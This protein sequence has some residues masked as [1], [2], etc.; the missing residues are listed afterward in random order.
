MTVLRYDDYAHQRDFTADVAVVGT[1]AGGAVAAAELAEAGLDVVM[2]EEGDHHPT[3]SFNP[4]LAETQ[5]RLY[6]DVAG[7]LLFGNPPIPYLE[8]RCVGGSTVIN[9]GMAWRAPEEVLAEWAQRT[10]SEDLGPER[11]APRFDR[12]EASVHARPQI[13]ESIGADN[14]MMREGARR[15]DWRWDENLRAQDHCVGTNQCTMGCPTG[16]K[17]STLVNYVPRA[18]AAGARCL[19]GVRVRKLRIERGRCTGVEGVAPEPRNRRDGHRVTVR[20]RTVVVAC[21]AVQ[22]PHLLKRHRLGRPSRRLGRH[23]L[24]HPNVKTMAVFPDA[25]DA[26]KGVNQW[27]QVR[28]FH[29]EGIVLALNMVA[30]GQ[31]GAS[32]PWIDDEAW[33]LLT[34]YRRMV[35][36]GGLIEDSTSGVVRRGPGDFALPTYRV[37]RYDHER[38]MRAARLLGELWFEMGAESVLPPVDGMPPL[39]SPDDLRRLDADRVRPKDVDL[40]TVHLMGTAGMGAT[41]EGSVVDPRGELWDLPGCRVADASVFPTSVGVNPQITIMAMATRIAESLAEELLDGPSRAAA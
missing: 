30:P 5:P 26:W 25:L 8:G 4:Y 31:L 23:L 24:C 33:E 37:T 29:D 21:G 38:F 9:G 13:P 34:Q 16:G 7:T 20:T 17:Q 2:V 10:G 19:T 14:R 39:R 22:T 6:R 15:L 12:V 28:Q 11:M 36:G 1:G 35:V 32:I 3:S 41:P 40:F 18:F 27:G